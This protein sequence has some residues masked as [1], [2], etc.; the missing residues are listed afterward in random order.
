MTTR[1]CTLY[2]VRHGQT[3]WNAMQKVQGHSDIALN[4]EGENQAKSLGKQLG[5]ISFDAVF[6]SDLVRA[7]K[8]A[9][10]ALLEKNIVVQTTEVL[11][12][13]FMGELEGAHR[14]EFLRLERLR[15][16]LTKEQRLVHRLVPSMESEEEVIARVITYLREIA[17]AYSGKT[18]LM[19]SHGAV[20]RILLYHLGFF[21]QQ[22]PIKTIENTAYIK[23][24]SDGVDFFVDE[25]K[26]IERY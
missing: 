17:V 24:R 14:D 13:R 5:H 8:T 22:H 11:R 26:G 16:D 21:D 25:T 3:D 10:L 20:M 12:E 23:M 7:K 9:E 2:L 1:F 6:S 18:V 4:S 19:V 15:G